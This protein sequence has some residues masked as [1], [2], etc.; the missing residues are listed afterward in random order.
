MFGR[1]LPPG[2]VY[3]LVCISFPLFFQVIINSTLTE[4]MTF[5]KTSQKFGQWADS[6]TGGVHGLGFNSEG[7]LTEVRLNL[8][9]MIVPSVD[10]CYPSPKWQ[11]VLW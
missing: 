3:V 4:K 9:V 11:L 6:K 10:V 7:E 2:N 1:I 5:K 8:I